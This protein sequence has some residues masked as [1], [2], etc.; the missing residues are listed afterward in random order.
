MT[1]HIKEI[2]NQS[3]LIRNRWIKLAE[4]LESGQYKQEKGN[5]S[6]QPNCFCIEGIMCDLSEMGTWIEDTINGCRAYQITFEGG[7]KIALGFGMPSM[8]QRYYGM[9]T[10]HFHY[11][12]NGMI[13]LILLND[14]VGYTFKQ[15]AEL[16][17]QN[18]E[19]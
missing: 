11:D 3:E 7:G 6:T 2:I 18:I 17:R 12:E 10:S 14:R 16:I 9:K 8:V 13:S 4:A 19:E 15:F 5:L 1:Q